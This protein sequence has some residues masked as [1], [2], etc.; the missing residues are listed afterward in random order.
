MKQNEERQLS[1]KFAAL[2]AESR[3][4][5][6]GTVTKQG[7]PKVSYAPFVRR[8]GSSFYVYLSR[9]SERT[10][11]LIE[12]PVA[13]VLL[14]E[15]ESKA[16]QI[17]ARMRIT[18]QCEVSVIDSSSSDYERTMRR[19]SQSFGS[20]I[21]VLTALPDFAL[22]RLVPQS[23]RFITG[24]GQ[25]YDLT[26]EQLDQLRHIGPEQIKEPPSIE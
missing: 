26:G 16:A 12:R 22:F 20:L 7:L 8:E 5:I 14:I 19:F 10:T 2:L 4:L 24:F 23:G 21:D 3:S 18:Y 6:L 1:D 9:L 11:D 13:S 17:F 15:D 25:A